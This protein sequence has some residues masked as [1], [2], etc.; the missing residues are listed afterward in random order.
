MD[1]KVVSKGI[2]K[3][4]NA[5]LKETMGGCDS[6]YEDLD[7][8]IKL[9]EKCIPIFRDT[10]LTIHDDTLAP[11]YNGRLNRIEQIE[12]HI[13]LNLDTAQTTQNILDRFK[14]VAEE[15]QAVLVEYRLRLNKNKLDFG[16]QGQLKQELRKKLIED[17]SYLTKS[18]GNEYDTKAL[19]TLIKSPYQK[20][21]S[22][23]GK[24][25]RRKRKHKSS[26]RK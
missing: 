2:G 6:C 20:P 3:E 5:F 25:H 24:T 4:I 13:E 17:P 9:M 12:E 19:K 14:S 18:L 8:Q 10:N 11:D 23:G 15:F 16:L 21:G 7:N 26:R 22:M 1:S